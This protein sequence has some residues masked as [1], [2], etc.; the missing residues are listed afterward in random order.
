M[1]DS[2]LCLLQWLMPILQ[3]KE[4]IEWSENMRHFDV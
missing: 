3:Q 1:T 2:A 4:Q